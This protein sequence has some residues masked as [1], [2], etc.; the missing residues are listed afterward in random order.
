MVDASQPPPDLSTLTVGDEAFELAVALDDGEP[1]EPFA[2]WPGTWVVPRRMEEPVLA[3]E[4]PWPVLASLG[5]AGGHLVLANLEAAGSVDLVGP[6][7][8]VLSVLRSMV[9]ELASSP[10]AA[11]VDLVLVGFDGA[12]EALQRSRAAD[13]LADV[14]AELA[15]RRREIDSYAA[16]LGGG[17]LARLRLFTGGDRLAPTVVVSTRAPS[18]QEANRLVELCRPGG[19]LVVVAPSLNGAAWQID[20]SAPVAVLDPVGLHLDPVGMGPEDWSATAELLAVAADTTDAQEPSPDMGVG[21]VIEGGEN[22]APVL[23]LGVNGCVPAGDRGSIDRTTLPREETD[24]RVLSRE[25][26][27]EPG[28]ERE[29]SGAD[30]C[31][32]WVADASPALAGVEVAVLGPVELRGV[33]EGPMRSKV[34]ELIV[35]LAMADHPVPTSKV[36]DALWGVAAE[37]TVHSNIS[38]ARQVLGKGD[39]GRPL[40]PRT[41]RRGELS[42]DPLVTTDWARFQSLAATNDPE[43]LRA[44]LALVRGRPLDGL[45][46][47]WPYEDQHIYVMESRIVDLAERL[48]QLCLAA[49]D[50]PGAR[51][52]ARQG[53][54]VASYDERLWRILLRAARIDGGHRAVEAIWHECC[55]VLEATMEPW[56]SLQ[57]ETVELYR[58]LNGVEQRSAGLGARGGP[59]R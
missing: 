11:S 52:A 8:R 47:N 25:T 13:D 15:Y 26:G 54:L 3:D 58:G 20:L 50:G 14:V 24:E 6:E 40:L 59:S 36:T 55:R 1:P 4:Q 57:P 2:S 37:A 39:D 17:G 51:W 18:P 28:P 42:V 19:A 31:S 33:A 46:G 34:T 27:V 45:S 32:P 5:L 35:Y 44:A 49:G 41:G 9:A 53:L 23:G 30:R 38:R 56:D 21:P 29:D 7:D 43:G 10:W 12:L 16:E 48:G 22:P